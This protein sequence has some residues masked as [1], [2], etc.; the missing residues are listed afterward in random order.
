VKIV[1]V[2]YTADVSLSVSSG[3][4]GS[5][6]ALALP[7]GFP[8]RRIDV[9]PVE[10][11]ALSD[12]E[13][14]DAADELP[15]S[16][17]WVRDHQGSVAEAAN[18]RAE[19][20]DKCQA[21]ER[22]RRGDVEEEAF[23]ELS[24]ESGVFVIQ[25][26]RMADLMHGDREQIDATCGVARCLAEY[27]PDVELS[28]H[29][30][31]QIRRIAQVLGVVPRGGI[32]EPAREATFPRPRG[33]VPEENARARDPDGVAALFENPLERELAPGVSPAKLDGDDPLAATLMEDA[34]P[35]FRGDLE[36]VL[37]IASACDGRIWRGRSSDKNRPDVQT[38][39]GRLR[40]GQDQKAREYSVLNYLFRFHG[41]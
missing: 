24:R 40:P 20:K 29:D 15:P 34:L 12:G 14:I 30:I 38:G 31:G 18:M 5:D 25:P 4:S 17:R 28:A 33:R 13:H 27:P 23:P 6:L 1:I 21:S 16:R 19:I 9:R 41:G 7:L 39:E 37:K 26:E 8:G 2:R 10:G 36:D 32:G 22:A 11:T 35:G 3:W